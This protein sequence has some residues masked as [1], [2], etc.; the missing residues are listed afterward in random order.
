MDIQLQRGRTNHYCFIRDAAVKGTHATPRGEL[1]FHMEFVDFVASVD[2]ED[3]GDNV[4]KGERDLTVAELAAWWADPA[5]KGW[6]IVD[7]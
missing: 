2:D 6:H 7:A 3:E 5:N 4:P 1:R